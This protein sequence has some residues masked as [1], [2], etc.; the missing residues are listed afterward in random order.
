LLEFD[1]PPDARFHF[2]DQKVSKIPLHELFP[3]R[4]EGRRFYC[5]KKTPDVID[6]LEFP[7]H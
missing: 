4:S 1:S 2:K 6:K 5:F 7:F 3:R